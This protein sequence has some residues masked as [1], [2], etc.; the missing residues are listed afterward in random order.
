M[1][2]RSVPRTHAAAPADEPLRALVEA[3]RLAPSGH[4]AQPW[5]FRVVGRALELHADRARSL[6]LADP[7][8]RERT[9]ACGAA[10]LHVRLAAA[11]LGRVAVVELLP[12]PG[13]AD[14]LARVLLADE[15]RAT[16]DE[17]RL[18]EAMSRRH[19]HREA[20]PPWPVDEDLLCELVHAAAVER[21]W[22]HVVSG[23]RAGVAALVAEADRRQGAD[24]ALRRERSAWLR[25]NRSQRTDG[26]PMRAFGLGDVASCLMP[27]VERAFDRGGNRAA[28]EVRA[29][30][31]AP[32][33]VV[34]GTER[35]DPRAWL[36]V[37][38][39]LGRVLL[40]ACAGG[41]SGSFLNAP[42]QVPRLREQLAS[43]LGRRGFPQVML[44]LGYG[45]AAAVAPR[46]RLEDV[47]E[48]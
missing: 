27:L 16:P 46:R 22:L 6:P 38:Q 42:I 29:V 41:V 23:D 12:V 20:F 30:H 18:I 26:V 28:A 4:N 31:E 19:T 2:T 43:E 32:S 15:R 17:L 45:R 36:Q 5:T 44:R 14:S 33:L 25:A 24:P 35:D 10:L 13:D 9:I 40:T 34:L 21:A 7:D 11:R 37:G 3:A 39:A 48:R 1:K 8:G 47:L